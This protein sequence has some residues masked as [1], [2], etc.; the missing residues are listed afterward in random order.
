MLQNNRGRTYNVSELLR[1]NQQGIN[2]DTIQKSYKL[3]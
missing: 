3:N 2:T 1:E